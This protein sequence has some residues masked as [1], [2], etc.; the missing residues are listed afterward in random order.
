MPLT[1]PFLAAPAAPG[2]R[3]LLKAHPGISVAEVA[4]PAIFN[5]GGER[6]RPG[7]AVPGGAGGR[8]P[9]RSPDPPG[10]PAA[11]AALRARRGT[12]V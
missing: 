4:L 2:A 5:L 11:A 1:A 10:G 3:P 7:G 9:A 8:S 6:P 12:Q